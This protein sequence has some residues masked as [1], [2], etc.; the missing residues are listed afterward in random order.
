MT[1]VGGNFWNLYIYNPRVNGVSLSYV[2]QAQSAPDCTTD[3]QRKKLIAD[4]IACAPLSGAYFQADTRK[5]HQLLKNYLMAKKSE[6]WISSIKKR[7]SCQDYFD[8]LIRH[9][10]FEGNISR[11]VTMSDLLQEILHYKSKRTLSFKK[12]LDR[13]QK[14]FNIF[15]DKGGPM[16]NSTQVCELFRRVQNPQLQDKFKALEVRSDLHSITYS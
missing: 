1:W 6:Q 5:V 14:M 15:L 9:Y 7:A 11:R 10:S 12:F 13:M 3:L 16:A 4:T 8:A 2:V